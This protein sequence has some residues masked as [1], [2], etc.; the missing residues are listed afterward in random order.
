MQILLEICKGVRF[1]R[2]P[3]CKLIIQS[4]QEQSGKGLRFGRRVKGTGYS[5]LMETEKLGETKLVSQTE[6]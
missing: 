2:E 3:G 5:T 6:D 4:N 1:V